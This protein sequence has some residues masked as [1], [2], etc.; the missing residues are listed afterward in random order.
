MSKEDIILRIMKHTDN[1]NRIVVPDNVV[2][3]L[4]RDYYM[5][6]YADKIILIPI[7]KEN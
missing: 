5:E 4:G 1:N 7:K 6:I 2:K 3:T